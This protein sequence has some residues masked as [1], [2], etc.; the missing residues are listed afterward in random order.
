MSRKR[1]SLNQD[2]FTRIRPQILIRD[3]CKCII[4][5]YQSWSNDVHHI[6]D[7]NTDN[8][9]MNLITV[10]K[11]HHRLI[12]CHVLKLDISDVKASLMPV[13]FY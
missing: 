3:A 7:I 10:C 13:V 12:T 5:G 2:W 4:C 6:N 8:D 1:P 9:P 11:R